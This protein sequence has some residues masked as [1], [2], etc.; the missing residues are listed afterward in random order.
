MI[1]LRCKRELMSFA[2]FMMLGKGAGQGRKKQRGWKN[3]R[4][5]AASKKSH[6]TFFFK[7]VTIKVDCSMSISRHP[8]GGLLVVRNVRWDQYST[9]FDSD[10]TGDFLRMQHSGR[11]GRSRKAPEVQL[12]APD[13]WKNTS[14]L[15]MITF[16][17]RAVK[18]PLV[19]FNMMRRKRRK[20]LIWVIL[21]M[22]ML[23]EIWSPN[24]KICLSFREWLN[25]F[26]L[27]WINFLQRKQPSSASA[28]N[29]TQASVME[30]LQNPMN[31]MGFQLPHPWKLSRSTDWSKIRNS[32]RCFHQDFCRW[33]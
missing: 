10:A 9:D 16:Q 24:V 30:H 6:Q 23:G 13:G 8:V 11:A 25:V 33:N 3:C 14:P 26:G 21:G 27:T 32:C 1:S 22:R 28:W 2:S 18:L 4:V 31:I 5:L 7:L 29:T 15:R 17:G 12:L 20:R 19:S